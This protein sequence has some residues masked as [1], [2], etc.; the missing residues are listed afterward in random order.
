MLDPSPIIA[1]SCQSVSSRFEFCS[2]FCM[3]CYMHLSKLIYIFLLKLLHGFVKIGIL[4]S[5]SF[6]MDLSKLLH[7]FVKV[8]AQICQ[9]CSMFYLLFAEQSHAEV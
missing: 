2:S 3:D 6:Y 4:I 7:G 8:D 9:S 1:L 5:L